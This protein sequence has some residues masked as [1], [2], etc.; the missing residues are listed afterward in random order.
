MWEGE[1]GHSLLHFMQ[2]QKS[3]RMSEEDQNA[4]LLLLEISVIT[5]V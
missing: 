4:V 1:N 3:F 5:L 2:L